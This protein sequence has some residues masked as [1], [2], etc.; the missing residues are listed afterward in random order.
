MKRR[1][2]LFLMVLTVMLLSGPMRSEAIDV[3]LK[4]PPESLDQYY[5]PLSKE[6]KWIQA[7]HQLSKH[8]GGVFLDMKEKDWEN[9]DKHADQL[10]EA[11]KKTSE[12]V[13]EWK[14]Y[15]DNKA[16]ETFAAAVKTHNPEEIGKAS[17][18]VGK[19][20]GKCHKENTVPVYTR[21]H[22]PSVEKIMLTDPVD[23]K[24]LKFGK[25]MHL[26]SNTFKGVTVNFGE[27]QTDR[28]LK[29][30]DLF[31]KRFVELKSTCAKCHVDDAV[32]QFFVSDMVLGAMDDLKAELKKE[33]PEPGTVWKNVGII[34]KRGCKQC[35]LTH[36]SYSIIQETWAA[37]K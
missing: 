8:F 13:E 12:M 11:Y 29:A 24:E 10:V 19:T 14:D 31:K 4:K 35:H 33:K 18:A 30:A 5:P 16:V 26:L 20:C 21:Y 25:Y 7:M 3:V 27:G 2:A 1:F 34:G 6:P 23:E 17:K 15:F 22:W 32:K 28:A 36:R 37:E 9:A